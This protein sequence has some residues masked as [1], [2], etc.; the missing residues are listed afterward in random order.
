MTVDSTMTSPWRSDLLAS[1]PGI[2]HGITRRV[3]GMGQADGNVGFSPPR[4]KADA[5]DMRRQ[6]CAAAGLTADHLV[7]LGQVHGAVV[8]LATSR[9]AGWGA[10]PGSTQIGYGDG[11]ITDTAGP[12]LMTLHA[13]CQPL[14]LVD[15]G[16]TRRG[17]AVG[18]AHA[19]WRGTVAD[20]A[21]ATLA[22][23]SAAF[24]TRP[25]DVHVVLGP[26]IGPCCYEVGDEVASAWRQ[27][28]GADAEAALIRTAERHRLSLRDGTAL[29]LRRAGV[30]DDHIEVSAA[31]TRCGGES[32]FS[33]RG[34]G[35]GTGRFGAMIA[36]S[37]QSA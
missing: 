5:W 17:P 33:H 24:G 34:Q 11:L 3:P 7:T 25:A 21:G 1:I 14:L 4:D 27:L 9:H 2:V 37:G 13:D 28:A 15:P 16:T 8:H 35:A 29:L 20:I 36:I 19:G 6:W 30:R 10:T 22:A 31:C 26:A 23:M 18:V 32:W 12:I